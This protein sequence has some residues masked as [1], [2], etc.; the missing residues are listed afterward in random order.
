MLANMPISAYKIKL[1]HCFV[2]YVFVEKFLCTVYKEWYQVVKQNYIYL[3][4]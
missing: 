1:L 4:I 2:F 3:A